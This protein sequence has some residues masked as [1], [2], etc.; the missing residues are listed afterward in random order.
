MGDRVWLAAENIQTQ[1]PSK[2]LDHKRLVP[3]EVVEKISDAAYRLKLPDSMKVHDVFHVG[4]LSRSK[5]DP[6]R[7]FEQPPPVVVESGEEEYEVE[8]IIDSKRVNK[9]WQY[10]VRWKGYGPEEDTW[11]PKESLIGN[12]KDELARYHRAQLRRAR[13]SAK[14][15]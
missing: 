15:R 4:L 9:G 11:E 6:D 12:A 1:R 14:R 10:R 3:F 5:T 2:K 13:D 8:A 7:H